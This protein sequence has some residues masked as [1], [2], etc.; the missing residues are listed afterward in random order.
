MALLVLTLALVAGIALERRHRR[1]RHLRPEEIPVRRVPTGTITTATVVVTGLLLDTLPHDTP[2]ARVALGLH[3][4]V[5]VAGVA[6]CVV[7]AAV[8]RLPDTITIPL[9]G[10]TIVGFATLGAVAAATSQ[11]TAALDAGRALLAGL[12]APVV[13]LLLTLTIGGI[14]LG[15]AKFACPLGAVLG[16]HGW[17]CVVEGFALAWVLAGL[18]AAWWLLRRRAHRDSPLPLGPFLG[19]GA[20]LAVLA[21]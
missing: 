12:A 5:A 7:D 8:H 20:L 14:G 2:A 18:T 21:A 6:A 4:V 3:L 13:F 1:G 11:E 17:G 19:A 10:V 9:A 15:D 16:W